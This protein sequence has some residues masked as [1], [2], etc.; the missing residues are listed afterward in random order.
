V[1]PPK[2]NDD[3]VARIIARNEPMRVRERIREL[4]KVGLWRASEMK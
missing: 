4:E 2:C 1:A 3:L